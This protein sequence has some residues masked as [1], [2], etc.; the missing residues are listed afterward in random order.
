[1][2]ASTLSPNTSGLR[3]QE[4]RLL[5]ALGYREQTMVDLRL[6][7]SW[8]ERISSQPRKLLWRLAQKGVAH[9]L[10]GGRYLVDLEAIPRTRP[11]I[12]SLEPLGAF[13]LQRLDRDGY[14]SWHSALWHHKLIDQQSRRLF[15]AV[16]QKKRPAQFGVWSVR[17]ITCAPRKFFVDRQDGRAGQPVASVE[18]ALIDSFDR[19]ELA[20]GMGVVVSALA[21]AQRI[22]VLDPD[23]LVSL[24]LLFDSPTLNR[25]LGFFMDHL[26]MP[27]AARLLDHLGRGYAVPLEAGVPREEWGRVDTKWGVALV[28][29]LLNIVASPK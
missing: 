2:S 3:G 5:E 12:E 14:L 16:T 22:E 1:M 11:R 28:P 13:L 4:H 20:G 7:A 24:A 23:E 27:S 19:P 18:K 10:Q 29:E 6:D 26:G 8:L 17:F 9:R 25:R 15:V 21:K